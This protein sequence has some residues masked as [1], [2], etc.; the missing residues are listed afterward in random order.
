MVDQFEGA[1]PIEPS[2]KLLDEGISGG[3]MGDDAVPGLK[4][5]LFL[6]ERPQIEVDVSCCGERVF[7]G[8][9]RVQG[10]RLQPAPDDIIAVRMIQPILAYLPI[11]E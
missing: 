9:L 7:A 10:C 4:E 6:K 1:E 11:K 8:S 3:C 5:I 2:V